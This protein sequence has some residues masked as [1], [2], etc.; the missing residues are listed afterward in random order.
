MIDFYQ[1]LMR[2]ES[3]SEA[4]R[5]AKLSMIKGTASQPYYWAAFEMSG[6]PDTALTNANEEAATR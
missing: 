1:N 6:E 3:K 2:G 5:Q 4:L